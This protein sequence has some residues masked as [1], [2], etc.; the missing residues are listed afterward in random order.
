MVELRV[1]LPLLI[2]ESPTAVG[3]QVNQIL[4]EFLLDFSLLG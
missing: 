2:Q 4:L 3:G 1:P